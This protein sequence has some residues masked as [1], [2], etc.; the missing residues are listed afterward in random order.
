MITETEF[1]RLFLRHETELRGFATTLM[2][3]HEDAED[4]LQEACVTMW[5]KIGELRDAESFRAWAYTFVR[6][7]ALNRIR[8][9]NRSPLLFSEKL[10]ELL[11]DEG[12]Q[13]ADRSHAELEA[14]TRCLETLPAK[15]LDLI[16][17]YYASAEVRMAEVA[18]ALQ[19]STAGLYKALERSREALR[20]CIE[21]RLAA[22]GY[23]KGTRS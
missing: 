5:Q 23:E 2:L 12:E 11:A 16:R 19:K 13:E 6:F 8:K 20:T 3:R 7:T 15:Q 17:R 18:E 10:M 9:R 21:N 14:L 1:I 4:V 22:G